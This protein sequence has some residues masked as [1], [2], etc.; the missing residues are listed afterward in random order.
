MPGG[1]YVLEVERFFS[2]TAPAGAE[3]PFDTLTTDRAQPVRQIILVAV[4]KFVEQILCGGKVVLFNPQLGP[5]FSRRQFAG[6]TAKVFVFHPRIDI[7]RLQQIA[8]VVNQQ[9]IG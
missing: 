9:D 8:D 3:L 6:A 5:C 1:R 4:K 7:R 2:S